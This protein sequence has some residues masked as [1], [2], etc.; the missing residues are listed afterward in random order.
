MKLRISIGFKIAFIIFVTLIS[1]TEFFTSYFKGVYAEDFKR[2]T[3]ANLMNSAK[4]IAS[5]IDGDTH[6][7]AVDK[8]SVEHY[9]KIK[10]YLEK[11]K[12]SIDFKEEIFTVFL[13]DETT[14]CY[15]VK[16][17][18]DYIAHEGC[19]FR[20]SSL[21]PVF[22]KS[23]KEGM[24]I[25]SDIYHDRYNVWISGFAPIKSSD[26]KV[27][28]V[29]ELDITFNEYKMKLEEISA[30]VNN[31]RIFGFSFSIFLGILIGFIF[32]KPISKISQAMKKVSNQ[33][34]T[35]HFE[36][37]KFKQ[38]FPDETVDLMETF[39]L[40]STKLNNALSD[41]M[42]ANIKL[43]ELD[44]SKSVFLDLIAH[45]LRTP[46]TG[47]G[48]IEY[49]NQYHTCGE[50]EAE[51][52]SALNDSYQR[53]K[54]F[55][56]SAEKYIR[57]LNFNI[58]EDDSVNLLESF[59]S[60]ISDIIL[61]SSKKNINVNIKS[62]NSNPTLFVQNDVLNQIINIVA[63]NSIKFSDENSI[64]EVM[65]EDYSEHSIIRIKDFGKGIKIE[66]LER[67]F[68]PYFVDDINSHSQGK[69]VNLAIARTLIRKYNG[70]IIS[71]SDGNGNGTE[72]VI[73]LKH[74]L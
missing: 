4:I 24:P 16:T 48:F 28:A 35:S 64:I 69:G 30:S 74:K 62:G 1:V 27:V 34:F 50:D 53:I 59:S 19:A 31:L 36:I 2:N 26:N 57:A 44:H 45:E 58:N 46:L 8:Y 5:N 39:N 73:K 29:L 9:D 70:D 23:F 12:K 7:L 40:M 17:N 37:G 63:D 52:I 10:I 22:I 67:I 72:F 66:N 68:E 65:T 49:L 41:L 56:D 32:G 55:A 14:S 33:E 25:Y 13:H 61:K 3:Q 18:T 42:K 54:S 71:K 38:V 20:D 43:A 15:G 6:N 21:I 60:T 51:I 47:L 11:V